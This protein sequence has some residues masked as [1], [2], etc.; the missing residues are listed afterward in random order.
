MSRVARSQ[1]SRVWPCGANQARLAAGDPCRS[2]DGGL[3][4]LAD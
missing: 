1:P 2:P 4:A 3:A